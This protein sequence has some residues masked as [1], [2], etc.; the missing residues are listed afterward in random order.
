MVLD[1]P[2]RKIGVLGFSFKA[3]TDDLRESPIVTLVEQL[4][5]KGYDILLYDRNVSLA[6]LTGANKAYIEERIPHLAKLM[7]DSVD[8]ILDHAEV[9]VVGTADQ[10]FKGVLD[11]VRPGQTVIDLVRIQDGRSDGIGYQGICW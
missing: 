8:Q 10:E 4:L 5:G 11:K 3:G 9:I 6:R 1:S 7:V 2:G